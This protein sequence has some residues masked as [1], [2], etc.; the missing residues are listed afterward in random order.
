MSLDNRL[1]N[2]GMWMQRTEEMRK[3]TC[4]WVLKGITTT[5][6]LPVWT[7]MKVYSFELELRHA[8]S[9][10]NLLVGIRRFFLKFCRLVRTLGNLMETTDTTKI[11]C[12]FWYCNQL[13]TRCT[14][15]TLAAEIVRRRHIDTCPFMLPVTS[16]TFRREVNPYIYTRGSHQT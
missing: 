13:G 12:R 15:I 6:R 11:W 10:P 1:K 3:A 7:A 4:E 5:Y 14:A 2:C 8:S 16:K 9:I